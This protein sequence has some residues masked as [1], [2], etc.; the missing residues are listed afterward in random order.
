MRN[1]DRRIEPG[2]IKSRQDL[3]YSPRH[4]WK[5]SRGSSGIQ[6]CA[7]IEVVAGSN[8]LPA[9]V[10]RIHRGFLNTFLTRPPRQ[11]SQATTTKTAYTSR[12]WMYAGHRSTTAAPCCENTIYVFRIPQ[13]NEYDVIPSEQRYIIPGMCYST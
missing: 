5:L 3:A 8:P 6:R 1:H 11:T 9:V 10:F 13:K 4:D 12:G 2:K 7:T